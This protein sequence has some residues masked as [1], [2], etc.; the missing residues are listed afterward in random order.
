LACE[1]KTTHR[2]DSR[3]G[4]NREK[5]GTEYTALMARTEGGAIDFRSAPRNAN[6]LVDWVSGR[7]DLITKKHP[8]TRRNSGI[9]ASNN[10]TVYTTKD[11]DRRI[12]KA[13]PV[14]STRLAKN[15]KVSRDA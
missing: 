2:S 15:Y 1:G 11:R 6:Y 13:V 5:D 7:C 12:L 4:R 10:F 14:L 8:S 9:L 3:G